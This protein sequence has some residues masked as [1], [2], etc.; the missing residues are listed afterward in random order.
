MKK[1]MSSSAKRFQ[2]SL[3]LFS[4]VW[5][6]VLPVVASCQSKPSPED[7]RASGI[8]FDIA[9][10]KIDKS[11]GFPQIREGTDG[12]SFKITDMSLEG[13]LYYAFDVQNGDLLSGYPKWVA[14]EHYD[15]EAKVAQD[16][17][18]AFKKLD[19]AQRRIMLRN[20]LA[21]RFHLK[22]HLQPKEV[23]VYALIVSKKGIKMSEI[24]SDELDG[25]K[26]PNGASF[27]IGPGQMRYE[28]ISM[29]RFTR[30]LSGICDCQVVDRTGLKGRFNFSLRWDP[31][32][33][34]HQVVAGTTMSAEDEGNQPSIFTAIQEQLGLKLERT[35]VVLSAI[36][37]DSV[38]RPS[39]N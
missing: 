38:Q 18:L 10:I 31:D 36:V 3:K 15:I 39:E 25:S 16:D 19:S 4:V 21:D 8:A 12:G 35:K 20:L 13:M 29:D 28:A 24:K 7:I 5:L 23:F 22:F 1:E 32:Q 37:V 17:S 14:A 2:F 11:P 30:S 27:G 34:A 33:L 9:T 26:F 6:S